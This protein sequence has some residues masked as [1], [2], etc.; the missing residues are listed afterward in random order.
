MLA[1]SV[2]S[3]FA[4][5]AT[6]LADVPAGYKAVYLTSKVD[7]RLTIVP[8]AATAGSIIQVFVPP[9]TIIDDGDAKRCCF[10]V[11]P[12]PT[13]RRSNDMSRLMLETAQSSWPDLHF[14]WMEA[15]RVSIIQKPCG[16]MSLMLVISQPE[17]YG[18]R[19]RG[20]L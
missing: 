17:R 6:A 5:T 13:P 12:S 2:F 15:L 16:I 4:L 18:E 9:P 8:K 19:D 3:V 10:L 14:A 1:S 7:T 11:R 20:N